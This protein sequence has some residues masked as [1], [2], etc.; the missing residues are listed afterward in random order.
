[1]AQF[2]CDGCGCKVSDVDVQCPKCNAPIG[3]LQIVCKVCGCVL[4]ERNATLLENNVFSKETENYSCPN[5]CNGEIQTVFQYPNNGR[6]KYDVNHSY[7]D[8]AKR[9]FIF[10][11]DLM[12]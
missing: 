3:K 5:S 11:F 4:F 2:N 7:L 12:N 6:N 10:I 8:E 9:L 1:M